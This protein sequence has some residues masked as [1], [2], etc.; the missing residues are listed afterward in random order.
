MMY[1]NGKITGK[2]RKRGAFRSLRGNGRVNQP[3]D[4]LFN[5]DYYRLF[6]RALQEKGASGGVFLEK[7]KTYLKAK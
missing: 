1:N 4:G 7:R 6:Q 5:R 2:Q 3:R